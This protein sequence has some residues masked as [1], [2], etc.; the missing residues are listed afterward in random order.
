MPSILSLLC[1]PTQI[2]SVL[3]LIINWEN[4]SRVKLSDQGFYFKLSFS[5][6][7]AK[8]TSLYTLNLIQAI[9]FLLFRKFSHLIIYHPP[10]LKCVILLSLSSLFV[11]VVIFFVQFDQN[12]TVQSCIEIM[13]GDFIGVTKT[14][15]QLTSQ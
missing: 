5:S 15:I 12:S 10:F 1:F 7:P 13:T 4:L 9:A 11:V 6:T 8:N 2:S 3:F 14:R